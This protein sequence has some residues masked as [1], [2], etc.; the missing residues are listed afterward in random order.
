MDRIVGEFDD[1]LD[2]LRHFYDRFNLL[3]KQ[4]ESVCPGNLG[5]GVNQHC[6][7]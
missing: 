2:F 6:F 1:L 5:I 3:N 7:Q 4:P